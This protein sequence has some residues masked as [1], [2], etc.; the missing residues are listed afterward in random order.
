[1]SKARISFRTR[2]GSLV[3]TTPEVNVITATEQP[4]EA[5]GLPRAE[6]NRSPRAD[7]PGPRQP[8]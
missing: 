3:R 7:R 4:P 5:P 8:A 1:M 6:Q 2:L